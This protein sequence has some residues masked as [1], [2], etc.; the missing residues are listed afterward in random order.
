MLQNNSWNGVV[1]KYIVF[2]SITYVVYWFTNASANN[3]T[4]KNAGL[5]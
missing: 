5:F 1:H 2:V 4:L 3:H